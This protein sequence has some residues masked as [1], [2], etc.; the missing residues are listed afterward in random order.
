MK[1]NST[2]LQL[3]WSDALAT[4]IGLVDEQHQRL[5]AIYN[6]AAL[7]QQRLGR[8]DAST[9]H[10]LLDELLDYSRYH[11]R[12][13]ARLMRAWALDEA[14]CATHL[15]AHDRFVTFLQ[16][17]QGVARDHPED[18]IVDLLA[19]LAQWLL[20]HIA[21]VDARMARA[22][23][24]RQAAAHDG[25]TAPDAAAQHGD[26]VD[27]VSQLTDTLG[28]KTFELI[29]QRQKLLELQELYRAL[30]R[31]GDALIQSRSEHEMLAS[32]CDR[33]AQ[34]TP[35]HAVWVGRPAA[36]GVFEVLALAGQG[37]QQVR[38]APPRLTLDDTASVVVKA[39][40]SRDL[41]VCND[42]LADPS[43]RPWHAGFGKHRWRSL[44][45]VPVWRAL[46]V[47]GVL[48]FAV[49]RREAFDA[50]TVEVC[51][52][53]AALLGFGLD[54]F[55]L[56]SRIQSLQECEARMARTDALT[57]LPNRLAAEEYLPRAI[58]RARRQGMALAVAMLDLDDFKPV[59]DRYGHAVGDT[60][61]Q[62]LSSKLR[63]HL[64]QTDFLA[65]LGGDEFVILFE[66]LDP[67]RMAQQLESMLDRVHVAV[68]TP[69][70]LGQGRT[71][72]VGMSMGLAAFPRDALEPDA[73]LR[74]ADAAMYA[75]KA[76]KS[77]RERWWRF[78]RADSGD[79]HAPVRVDAL[80]PFDREAAALLGS[81]SE[82]ALDTAS[83]AFVAAFYDG[84]A[85]DP[86]TGPLLR[87]LSAGEFERLRRAQDGHLRFLL[88]P[89]NTPDALHGSAQ[90]IGLVHALVGVSSARM[91]SA[92]ALY[93]D[94]LRTQ[95]EA[96]LLSARQR[97]RIV[98]VAAAR[99]RLSV[100]SQLAAA[101]R[102]IDAYAEL[103]DAPLEPGAHWADA[104]QRTLDALALLPGVEHAIVYRPDEHG[105]LR[106]EAGAG[107]DFAARVQGGRSILPLPLLKPDSSAQLG[108][109]AMAWFTRSIQVVDAYLLDPR[110]QPWHGVARELGWRSA[111]TIPICGADGVDS[112][113]MLFGHYPRQFS[114]HWA[115]R[116]LDLLHGRVD[117]LF[118]ASARRRRPLQQ[119]QTRYFRELLYDQ[120]LSMWVQPIVDLRT[121]R[122]SKVEALA[123][124]QAPDG[125]V[126]LPGQFLPAFGE[127]ELH[128]LFRQGLRQSLQWLHDWR[129][130]GLDLDIAVNLPVETL[131]HRD[132]AN[133]VGGTL[134]DAHVAPQ[135]LSLE[136]LEEQ[137]MD[138]ARCDE[139]IHALSGVGVR[140]ALDD[141]GSG[142]SSLNRLASLP[143]DTVKIDQGLVRQLP[144][145]PLKTIRLLATVLHIGQD[146]AA[147][148]IVEGLENEA[149]IEVAQLLGAHYGQ[150]FGLA[151]P[152]PADAFMR[153]V[154]TSA[155]HP[156]AGAAD[157]RSWP[158]ALAYHV[159]GMRG[160]GP[161]AHAGALEDC[162]LARFL[163][164]RDVAEPEVQ[165]WHAAM[166]SAG[167]EDARDQGAEKLMVWLDAQVRAHGAAEPRGDSHDNA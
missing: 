74:R 156:L 120:R 39:W 121:G 109:L 91:V 132:C 4:G 46:Q 57:R 20:H 166:H 73:L 13:E 64:R 96:A 108:P 129:A 152:M 89:H 65:R 41:V 145:D 139:A 70:D 128:A 77:V 123:R 66:D 17:A 161:P 153:W 69:F 79:A 90:R 149:F 52:R 47:W 151:R 38:D 34:D 36:S 111:A 63:A 60:L 15:Q 1:P 157:V 87:C 102:T 98:R 83:K 58:A 117:A 118:A 8:D 164:A 2:G 85:D 92:F 14:Q 162:P 95:L 31:S 144:R 160:S 32:V 18:A 104:R 9:L 27:V 6:K 114:S 22:I 116:W 159:R 59:N 61:L 133:W 51:T 136:I 93:E 138:P 49:D 143:I 80:D 101:D 24:A 82:A 10:G 105:V 25:A 23:R 119:E 158:A 48:A 140:L 163:R 78:E 71:A 124:L 43:L 134:R 53:V 37:A 100:Q 16:R 167:A 35:F 62:E 56:K 86:E 29:D 55:D 19:F 148:T 130:A 76:R 12:E 97:Y 110:L 142:Y 112:V 75:S 81:L 5:I 135:H 165:A 3:D 40:H 26:L 103:L 84:L 106:I 67:E 99:L 150:G 68:E 154:A 137:D 146:F 88:S 127:Q 125:T 50:R 131:V 45:A 33:L 30:L 72:T 42:T 7:A 107:R 21:G 126:H 44:L 11:F 94:L 141:L 122:V 113:L 147:R 115:R 54:E 28:Q 155:G